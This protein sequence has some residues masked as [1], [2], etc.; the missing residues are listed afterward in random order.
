MSI[1]ISY[2]FNIILVGDSHVGKSHIVLR[3]VDGTYS[4]GTEA[5]IGVDY[6]IKLL[7]NENKLIKLCIWDTAGCERF[8]S[9]TK[10]Y[11]RE[12]VCTIFVFDLSDRASFENIRKWLYEVMKVNKVCYKI[13]VGTKCDLMNK[14]IGHDEIESLCEEHNM[15]YVETSSKLNSGINTLFEKICD[16]L[17]E[18]PVKLHDEI[19]T[20]VIINF[21]PNNRIINKCCNIF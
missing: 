21:E 18:H 11:Y 2:K 16:H 10:S 14:V 8:R 17:I 19:K 12:A 13:L 4:T 6:R 3:Y 20:D 15:E 9:I 1:R 5:T 7:E